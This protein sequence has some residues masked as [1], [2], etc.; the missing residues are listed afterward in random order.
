[1]E[2]FRKRFKQ[3]YGQDVVI[4]APYPYDAKG[5]LQNAT[6]TLYTFKDG[7]RESLG[8]QR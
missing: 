2:N 3:K 1:M 4:D 6:L 7:K 5:D 8:V